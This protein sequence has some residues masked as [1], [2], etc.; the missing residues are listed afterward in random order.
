MKELAAGEELTAEAKKKVN[1]VVAE[2]IRL[3]ESYQRA[4]NRKRH[5]EIE[6]ALNKNEAQLIKDTEAAY[7]RLTQAQREYVSAVKSENEDRQNYWQQEI[8]SS[9]A[10]LQTTRES[11]EA[12]SWSE[13][14]K[15]RI[16]QITND[17]D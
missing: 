7:K 1:N 5:D 13:K 9:A 14:T 17:A 11:V 10:A 6:S 8:D 4:R 16:I 2:S 12:S 15:E 3:E